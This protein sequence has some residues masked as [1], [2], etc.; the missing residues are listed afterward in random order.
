MCG[1]YSW[2]TADELA[3]RRFHAKA[4]EPLG[5]HYNA[6]P[7]QMLPVILNTEPRVIQLGRWGMIPTWHTEA[8]TDGFINARAESVEEQPAFRDAYNNRR[9][10]VLA[11]SFFEWKKMGRHKI[12]YR[13][14]LQSEEPFAFA[15]LWSKDWRS[16]HPTFAILTTAAKE[17]MKPIHDRMPVI[18]DVQTERKWLSAEGS[19]MIHA[20]LERNND[21]PVHAYQVSPLVNN[22]KNNEEQILKST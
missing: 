11:N 6:A 4:K 16:D 2:F 14:I 10:L 9:C 12:P 1:R 7:S 22:P 3:E 18:L 19:V 13:F 20:L 8:I 17:Y 21:I 5:V 15:G